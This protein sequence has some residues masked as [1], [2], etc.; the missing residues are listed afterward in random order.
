MGKRGTVHA[1]AKSREDLAQVPG[2][3]TQAVRW[4]EGLAA[5]GLSLLDSPLGYASAEHLAEMRE[6]IAYMRSI[7]M[8]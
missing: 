3:Q 8:D 1:F 4:A 6:A 2:L 7:G 5:K